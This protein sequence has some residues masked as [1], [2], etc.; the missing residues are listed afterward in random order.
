MVGV[1]HFSCSGTLRV[2]GLFYYFYIA[3][4]YILKEIVMADVTDLINAVSKGK[5]DNVGAMLTDNNQLTNQYD[6]SGATALHYAAMRGDRS[7]VMLLLSHG[8]SINSRDREHGATPAGWAIEYL[9]EQGGCLAIELDDVAYAIKNAD[10][11]WVMRFLERFPQLRE[12]KDVNGK[13]FRELARES[14]NPQIAALF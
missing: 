2:P 1:T 5:L 7:M 13:S 12:A 9:R 4:N 8:A 3:N 6:A 10:V 14:G 11:H